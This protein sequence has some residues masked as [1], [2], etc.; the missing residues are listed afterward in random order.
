MFKNKSKN[1]SFKLARLP[2]TPRAARLHGWRTY[3]QIHQRKENMLN[4]LEWC[5]KSNHVCRKSGI[6]CS[7]F[8]KKCIGINSENASDPNISESN[9]NNNIDSELDVEKSF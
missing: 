1:V 8:C 7:I 9:I 6:K 3:L 2:P 4:Q 5:W